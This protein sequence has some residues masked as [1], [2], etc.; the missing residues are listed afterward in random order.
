MPCE[1]K[2]GHKQSSNTAHSAQLALYTLML[3]VRY[4]S[5]AASVIGAKDTGM[6]LYLNGKGVNATHVK[7]NTNELKALIGQRNSHVA[8]FIQSQKPRGK[9]R[10]L[11]WEDEDDPADEEN[12]TI[13]NAGKCSSAINTDDGEDNRDDGISDAPAVLP[14][15][16]SSARECNYC[17]SKAECMLYKA[18]EQPTSSSPSDFAQANILKECTGHIQ[19]SHMNYFSV[20]DQLLDLEQD[21]SSFNIVRAWK[22]PSLQRERETGN[23]ISSLTFDS[24]YRDG[25]D[26]NNHDS[27]VALR[28]FRKDR[29]AEASSQRSSY[30]A[31]SA[32]TFGS[33]SAPNSRN[34]SN[35]HFHVGDLVVISTDDT[36]ANIENRPI[37]ANSS[38]NGNDN[39]NDDGNGNV[40]GNG[41]GNDNGNGNG[42]GNGN[43][44]DNGNGNGNGN[45]IGKARTR[46]RIQMHIIKGRVSTVVK[47]TIFV[48]CDKANKKRLVSFHRNGASFRIDK[49]EISSGTKYLRR[50]LVDVFSRDEDPIKDDRRAWLRSM[51]IDMDEPTFDESLIE[52]KFSVPKPFDQIHE[53]VVSGC[54]FEDLC[55]DYTEN[56]NSDQQNAVDRVISA[57]DYTLLQGLPG[58]GKSSTI[59]FIVK[60][61][62]ARRQRVLITSYT[63]TAVDNLLM[64]LGEEHVGVGAGYGDV[65][66][67]G[68]EST[69]HPNVQDL[70]VENVASKMYLDANGGNNKVG[71]REL[72]STMKSARIVGVTTLTAGKTPLLLNQHFDVVIVDEAGQ[73]SQP[74]LLGALAHARQ[75]I[76]VGDQQQLPPIVKSQSAASN[77][78]SISLLQR[79]AEKWGTTKLTLQYRMNSDICLLCNKL[80]Y[81]DALQ[82]VNVSVASRSLSLDEGVLNGF[83]ETHRAAGGADEGDDWVCEAVLPDRRVVFLDTDSLGDHLESMVLSKRRTGVA[84]TETGTGTET[85]AAGTTTTRGCKK[86]NRTEVKIVSKIVKSLEILNVPMDT[87]GIIAPYRSQIAALTSDEHLGKLKVGSGL[88]ISTV[89]SFQGRDKDVVIISFVRSNRERSVGQLLNDERRLNVAFSRAKSKLIMVGSGKTMEGPKSLKMGKVMK[90]IRE[91]GWIVPIGKL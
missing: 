2:T 76:L 1:L 80:V 87:V 31:S 75:F 61:L 27:T 54:D 66:R 14:D 74:A 79:L 57:R 10:L 4:G 46:T 89:D 38:A 52:T 70:L 22:I 62:V 40:N 6:L 49:D 7:P 56:L 67:I 77:G 26:S 69:C 32:S 82:P 8:S 3:R 72:L 85:G 81:N 53:E 30:S 71:T 84:E 5:E 23:T 37:K 15:T 48:K 12:E 47:N 64:K 17:Y 90:V 68:N 59:C 55:M 16:L 63:H 86:T 65:V 42:N 73:I 24:E 83:L 45:G 60:L 50:N 18:A 43:D 21:A 88:E 44:N 29:D 34:L 25:D 13:A 58:T 41:N 11:A 39:D 78:Y 20:W 51:V 36:L 33:F 28:F 91:K 19:S 9:Q 35:L